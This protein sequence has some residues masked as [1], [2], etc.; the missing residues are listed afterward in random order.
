MRTGASWLVLSS[1][2]LCLCPEGTHCPRWTCSSVWARASDGASQAAIDI[3]LHPEPRRVAPGPARLAEVGLGFCLPICIGMNGDPQGDISKSSPTR[4]CVLVTR[5]SPTL[6]N[7]KDCSQPG[8]SVHGI[9]QAGIL[10][11]VAIPFLRGS[12]RPKN[13]IQVS[14]IVGSFFTTWA[15]RKAL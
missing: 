2:T 1:S 10:E 13:Q 6:C 9:L 14:H 12:S 3:P 8:S 5:L 4:A 15:T 11:W 7:P